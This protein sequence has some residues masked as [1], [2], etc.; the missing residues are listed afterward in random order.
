MTI[1]ECDKFKDEC[2]VFGIYS[3]KKTTIAHY[4]YYG[5]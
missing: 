3:N 2:G 4:V 5:L 1:R